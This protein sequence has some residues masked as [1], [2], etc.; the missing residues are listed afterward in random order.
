LLVGLALAI[1]H[2]GGFGPIDLL[3]KRAGA[4][5]WLASVLGTL[6]VFT[7]ATW[8]YYVFG[9]GLWGRT[10]GLFAFGLKVL[11]ADGSGVGLGVSLKRM[12]ASSVIS[13][14]HFV[15]QYGGGYAIDY[16]PTLKTARRQALHD[17][18]AKTVV[19]R[20]ER[21]FLGRAWRR[22]LGLLGIRRR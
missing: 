18:V 7:L 12:L 6:G 16:L 9:I 10:V 3:G 21:Y 4:A 20:T 5:H 11:R 19:V 8:V 17:L 2:W 14:I 13:K 1:S 22:V 15:A